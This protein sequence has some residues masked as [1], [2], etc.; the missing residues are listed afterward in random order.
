MDEFNLKRLNLNNT[1]K[2][3]LLYWLNLDIIRIIINIVDIEYW[4]ENRMIQIV[5]KSLY[6]KYNS[7]SFLP[8]Y[9]KLI[10][11]DSLQFIPIINAAVLISN[12]DILIRLIKI[13]HYNIEE[14]IPKLND[15]WKILYYTPLMCA[16]YSGCSKSVNILIKNG[17]IIDAVWQGHTALSV[18]N[19]RKNHNIIKILINNDADKEW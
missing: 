10:N 14:H 8:Q 2:K 13:Y 3:V 7:K 4:T 16:A 17:A 9:N 11:T 5:K 15:L 1:I 6:N 18:A 12:S 19:Y